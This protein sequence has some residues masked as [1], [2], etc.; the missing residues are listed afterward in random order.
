MSKTNYSGDGDATENKVSKAE[1]LEKPKKSKM[2]TLRFRENRSFIL[3]VKG[4]EY[5]FGPFEAKQV[6][7][8]ILDEPEFQHDRKYFLIKE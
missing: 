8:S 4:Q 6:D 3:V 5:R 1:A 7:R 2:V